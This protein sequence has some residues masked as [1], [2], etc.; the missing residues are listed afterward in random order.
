MDLLGKRVLILGDTGTGKT[1]L[2]KRLLIEAIEEGHSQDI[3]VIE[4]APPSIE[5]RG[6][7]VG[8]VLLNSTPP[9]L[10]ILEGGEIKTP[11]LSARDGEEV[12]RLADYNRGVIEKLL[13]DFIRAPTKILFINDISLYLQ[14]GDLEYLWKVLQK[15]ETV[16]ANGYIG[17]KLKDDLGTGLSAREGQL[18]EMLASRTDVVIRFQ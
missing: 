7:S 17:E 15:A 6:L 5:L 10:R 9:K 3:T 4:M 14:R 8:G 18:I 2:T 16:I 11:R 13:E 1:R 12:L